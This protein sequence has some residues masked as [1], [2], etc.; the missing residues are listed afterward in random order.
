MRVAISLLVCMT[1]GIAQAM[2]ARLNFDAGAQ[3]PM[4]GGQLYHD[5]TVTYYPY[6][7]RQHAPDSEI[8]VAGSRQFTGQVTVTENNSLF[9][10]FFESRNDP[11]NSP[12]I[13]W[14]NGGPGGSS[15]NGLLKEVGPCSVNEHANTTVL[16][17]HSWTEFANVLFLDQ[18]AGVGFATVANGTD[19]PDNVAE[20]G[21]DFNR[22]LQTFYGAIF[23]E[24]AGNKLHIAGESFGGKFVPCY[25][26]YITKLQQVASPNVAPVPIESIILVNAV[27]DTLGAGVLGY[28][29][30]FCD[31]DGKPD[32]KYPFNETACR[33]MEVDT[34]E[35]ERLSALC[36][37]TYDPNVCY[38]ATM[39]C[40]DHLGKWLFGDIVKG[41]R[42]AY[43]DREICQDPPLCEDF[44]GN[45]SFAVF[46][47]L[48]HI[49]K[50]LGFGEEFT[51]QGINFE[52]NQ[53]WM[54]SRDAFVPS[55]REVSYL[56]DKTPTRVL[57]LNGNNDAVVT[58]EGQKRVFDHLP[59]SR[60]AAYRM[61]RFKEWQWPDESGKLTVGGEMKTADKLSFVSI[62]EAGH[63]APQFQREAVSF[64]MRCWIAGGSERDPRCPL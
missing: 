52:L 30:H 19:F 29:D 54:E 50:E 5:K 36:V 35:C 41:G 22:F 3:R 23:P 2:P 26:D 43:D 63:A 17:P 10:W 61:Y 57:V 38:S 48:L 46:L 25:A 7:V 44:S 60:Q 59:W 31:K 15:M 11:K 16:E 14:M 20:S 1:L 12:V 64:L 21:E 9:F 53:K 51:Y 49:K 18:P 40:D 27:V 42:D 24:L 13:I 56:L 6:T 39:F 32:M 34:P 8:C 37:E 55:T 28:Y 58:T 4:M 45:S 47:N 33:A 62:D